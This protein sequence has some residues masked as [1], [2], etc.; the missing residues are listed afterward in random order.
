[1]GC[2]SA[3]MLS[4]LKE[5]GD[6][7]LNTDKMTQQQKRVIKKTW[8]YL[9]DDM[10]GYG[11]QVFSRIFQLN[12]HVKKLFPCRDVEGDALLRDPNFKGHASRFMQAVGA[13]VDNIDDWDASLS[14]LLI[15]L[16]KQH[17]TFTGFKPEYFDAFT[18]AMMYVWEQTLGTKFNDITRDSWRTVFEFIMSTL[19]EG[20]EIAINEHPEGS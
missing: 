18:E 11:I 20:Y 14:P 13:A 1:M 17:I 9:S 6:Q 5:M 15:G 16:G 4:P 2:A 10:T 7:G 8:K 12:P 3:L 19:K